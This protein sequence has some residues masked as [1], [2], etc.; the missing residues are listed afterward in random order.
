MPHAKQKARIF[1][2]QKS[3]MQ[4]GRAGTSEWVLRF[5]PAEP[6]RIDPLTGWFGSG[7]TNATQVRL[8][9]PSVEAAIAYAEQRG[10]PY[11]V[12]AP[13]TVRADIK[14]KSY[15]DNFRFG[16]ADNWTH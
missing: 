1:R 14:P 12:E 4:S 15:S 2:E 9:F 6:K 7:D 16:R 5:E 11:E 10:I 13:P 3:A 8:A